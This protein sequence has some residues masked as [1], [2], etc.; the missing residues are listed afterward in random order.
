MRKTISAVSLLLIS[1]I[2]TLPVSASEI[3]YDKAEEAA[4][5]EC[6]GEVTPKYQ[7][8]LP[9]MIA[10]GKDTDSENK[11]AYIGRYQVAVSGNIEENQYV[12]VV[13][14][15]DNIF[16]MKDKA[17]KRT[18][19]PETT[20]EKFSWTAENLNTDPENDWVEEDSS[21]EAVVSK[22]GKY[23]GNLTYSFWL[24]SNNFTRTTERRHKVPEK[25]MITYSYNC[26]EEAIGGADTM[27]K[28]MKTYNT[29]LV[30]EENMFQ[31]PVKADDTDFTLEGDGYRYIKTYSYT[32]DGWN[33]EPD[34]S[35]Q[36][37]DENE[38]YKTNKKMN[39]YAQWDYK[40][41]KSNEEC[42]LDVNQGPNMK[43]V[44]GEG[45]HKKGSKV[46][47]SGIAK[48]D[49]KDKNYTTENGYRFKKDH[50][51]TINKVEKVM[52]SP[53]T[54]SVSATENE[55]KF[56]E[57]Y[58][59]SVNAGANIKSVSGEG[60]YKKGSKAV[61]S[62]TAEDDYTEPDFITEG[63]GYRYKKNHK[64]TINKVEKTM[65]SPQTASVSAT[66]TESKVNEQYK[67]TLSAG[68]NIKSVADISGW[69]DKGSKVKISASTKDNDTAY[70][71]ENNYRYKKS[72][73][74][75]KWSD[76]NTNNSREI[77]M[78]K[79]Y[80]LTAEGTQGKT[81]EQHRSWVLNCGKEAHTHS[82]DAPCHSTC[83][84]ILKIYKRSSKKTI[85][86]CS[87]CRRRVT[88]DGYEG[89]KCGKKTLKC[90][91]TEHTHSGSSS[92]GGGCYTKEVWS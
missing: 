85:Y 5:I 45:W 19:L 71:T 27:L 52:D 62:G 54:V 48:D 81:G 30:L 59:L 75:S 46:V 67:L 17:G 16:E 51:F 47:A 22:A 79:A 34:G 86:K 66:E 38:I 91:K 35:G 33:T 65:N 69:K 7:V 76:G 6:T 29:D 41:G 14:D 90:S 61:A 36:P 80:N 84:G 44:S 32:F 74:F 10:M 37:F 88:G 31:T 70:T 57:E 92:S 1:A 24:D 13:P 49:Y 55:T 11:N 2:L 26:P 28:Q 9:A 53:Q 73:S 39:L 72:Y 43:S 3:V 18:I 25:Y 21:I 23:S 50:K 87:I 64:F 58:Y 78:N 8:R 20:S 89:R 40:E 77:T 68:N 15:S 82:S 56:D 83:N 42:Y 60:W 63:D 12:N 4:E